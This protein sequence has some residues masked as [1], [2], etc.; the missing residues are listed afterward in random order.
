MLG[1]LFHLLQDRPLRT[2]PDQAAPDGEL[3]C[4][5]QALQRPRWN[6]HTDRVKGR[7]NLRHWRQLFR[8]HFMF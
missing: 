8:A 7:V 1:M 5:P 2:I 4:L 6:I 3:H